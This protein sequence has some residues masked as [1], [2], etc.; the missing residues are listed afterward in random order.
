MSSHASAT[1]GWSDLAANAPGITILHEAAR[2]RRE[3]GEG[4]DRSWRV[5]AD[6]ELAV[7]ALLTELTGPSSLRRRTPSWRVLHSIPVGERP[8]DIDHLLIGPP[9]VVTINTKHHREGRLV[10]DGDAIR[11]DDITTEYVARS[12]EEAAVTSA[13]LGAALRRAGRHQLAAALDVRPVIAVLGGLLHV[14]RWPAGVT[15]TTTTRLV[16]ALRTLPARIDSA[17][18]D[19]IFEVARRSTTWQ[20]ESVGN[21]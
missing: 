2:R 1:A 9:G 11:I 3:E 13:L 19:A 18:T 12:R 20:L 21:S 17:A 4:A 6:G 10:V 14:V 16:H 5:G 15:V 8:R 7:A